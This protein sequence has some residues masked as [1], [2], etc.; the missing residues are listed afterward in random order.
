MLDTIPLP[1]NKDL[2]K[3]TSLSVAPLFA[4]AIR[5]ITEDVPLSKLFD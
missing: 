4:E 1:K 3:F 2:K 5:R